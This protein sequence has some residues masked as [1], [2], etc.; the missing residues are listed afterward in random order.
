MKIFILVP[1]TESVNFG[2]PIGVYSSRDFALN[3][4][5]NDYVE[6]FPAIP[7][8]NI[9]SSESENVEVIICLNGKGDATIIYNIIVKMLDDASVESSLIS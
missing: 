4:I 9:L 6:R 5:K 1:K 2:L 8:G 3:A 7:I